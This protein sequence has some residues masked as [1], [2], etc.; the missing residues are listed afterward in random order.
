MNKRVVQIRKTKGLTQIEFAEKLGFSQSNLSAIELGKIPL[1][2]A[3]IRLICLTFGINEEWFRDG[4]GEMT[5]DEA[6]LSELEKKLLLLYRELDQKG[7]DM[8]IEYAKKLIEIQGAKETRK[9]VK[10]HL[11]KFYRDYAEKLGPEQEELKNRLLAT[12]QDI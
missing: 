7:K 9:I 12:I 3:N 11:D 5:D 10:E 2:E 6:L 1:T 4:T 8:L